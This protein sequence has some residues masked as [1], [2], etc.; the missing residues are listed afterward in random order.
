MRHR[1]ALIAIVA[2]VAVLASG[3]YP[4]VF[5][6]APLSVT[7]NRPAYV[8][9][10]EGGRLD[11]ECVLDVIATGAAVATAVAVSVAVPPT[12]ILIVA[13]WTLLGVTGAVTIEDCLISFRERVGPQ[14]I[15][16]G[17]IANCYV[18]GLSADDCAVALIV[19]E[20]EQE[21]LGLM[22]QFIIGGI[23]GARILM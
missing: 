11:D 3:C 4:E 13:G 16:K 21:E 10:H 9:V 19:Y 6:V 12:A 14:L 23:V 2:A 8:E 20:H 17:I 15:N 18:S 1:L 5:S 7:G 22:M